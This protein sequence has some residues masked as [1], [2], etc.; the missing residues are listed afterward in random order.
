MAELGWTL[1]DAGSCAVG[2]NAATR[3]RNAVI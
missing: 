3:A 1:I 2:R